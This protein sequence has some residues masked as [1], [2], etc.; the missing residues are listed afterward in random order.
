MR[1]AHEAALTV[2]IILADTMGGLMVAGIRPMSSEA[3]ATVDHALDLIAQTIER[4]A[5]ERAAELQGENLRLRAT[6]D[7]LCDEAAESKFT[8]V[9]FGQPSREQQMEGCLRRSLTVLQT[10]YDWAPDEGVTQLGREI[11]TI[12]GEVKE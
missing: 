5:D 8:P 4:Y 3:R 2:S 10:M 9:R 12:L 7:M 11:A 1:T 6:I